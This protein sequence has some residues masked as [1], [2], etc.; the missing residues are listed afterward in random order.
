M[1]FP[2]R[3]IPQSALEFLPSASRLVEI[4]CGIAPRNALVRN[5][6]CG[7]V[8]AD[9][10]VLSNQQ[11]KVFCHDIQ[12]TRCR[13]DRRHDLRKLIGVGANGPAKIADTSKG[14][15]LV[16]SKGMTLYTLDKD[17]GGKSMCNGPCADNWPPLMASADTKASGDWTVVT[18]DDGR[19]MRAFKGKPLYTRKKDSR[20]A[21][22]PATASTMASGMWRRPDRFKK[23]QQQPN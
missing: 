10:C 19:T 8:G 18:R 13:R 15:T 1:I 11:G 16:D 21:T 7:I 9:T 14:K 6:I 2:K 17:A 22:P 23:K 3:H 5:L 20:P 4:A 12:D